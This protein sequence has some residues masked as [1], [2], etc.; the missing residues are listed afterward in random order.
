[1]QWVSQSPILLAATECYGV[2]ERIKLHVPSNC[3]VELEFPVWFHN[4]GTK[5]KSELKSMIFF[6]LCVYSHE[7]VSARGPLESIDGSTIAVRLS[8]WVAC[9]GD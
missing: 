5:W 6:P 1:M 8:Q 3:W 7:M 9:E 4:N 2:S